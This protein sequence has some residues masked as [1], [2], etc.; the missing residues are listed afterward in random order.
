MNETES[1]RHTDPLYLLREIEAYLSFRLLADCV[2]TVP[3][4]DM[5]QMREDIAKCLELQHASY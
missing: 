4:G 2:P 1:K 3:P 5:R